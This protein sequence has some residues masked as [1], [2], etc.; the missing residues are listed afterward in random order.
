MSHPDAD[1]LAQLQ[2]MG[3]LNA[4]IPPVVL[5]AKSE[6]LFALGAL[7]VGLFPF[8]YLALIA[9]ALYFF[10]SASGAVPGA[11]S[12]LHSPVVS[13]AVLLIGCLLILSLLK[14]L[15]ARP[16][17]A[18]EPHYLDP[19]KQPLLFAFVRSLASSIGVASPQRIAVDCNVNCYC[20]FAGGIAG[21]FHSGFVLVIGL[22]LVAGLRLDQV[23]GVL[24]HEL[25]HAVQI[26]GMRSSHFIWGVHA[27]FSRV[28]FSQDEL[29]EWLLGCFETAGKATRPALRLI[30]LLI[31][32]GRGILRLLMMA[33][34]AVSSTFRRCIEIGADRYQIRVSGT[35]RF[36]SAVVEINLL[37][38]AAQ[39]AIVELS[40]MK[41]TGRLVD[42]Y[43]GLIASLRLRYPGDFVQRILAGM[44]EE[45]TGMFSA[46]P[47]DKDRIAL[48]R[49][50]HS[51]GVVTVDL[52]TSVLF[53][54]YPA[55]CREVT[56]EYYKQEFGLIPEGWE[57][58]PIDGT[59]NGRNDH[60]H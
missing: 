58:V 56:L 2:A 32:P 22:P 35:D 42:D 25:G 21:L 47:C 46:H 10:G 15:V 59:L 60:A 31:Q 37:A 6:V 27:W 14:P 43:P 41:R 36:V 19:E 52:P 9:W 18:A 5:S 55:L 12:I 38:V 3:V 28:A 48:A 34:T 20:M 17:P 8:A 40:R 54:Q 24:A 50:E 16:A 7:M 13:V 39:R 30:Q 1:T 23:A 57:L 26:T 29:D 33:E 45:K 53:A 49:A 51:Q 4:R 44:A 11:T